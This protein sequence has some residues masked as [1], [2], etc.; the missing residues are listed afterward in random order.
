M[1]VPTHERRDR[2][3]PVITVGLDGLNI[4]TRKKFKCSICGGTVFAYYDTVVF[5][6]PVDVTQSPDN[7]EF[8]P[9][10]GAFD[11]V[12]CTHYMKDDSGKRQRCRTIYIISRP[13]NG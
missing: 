5:L 10:D 2:T 8:A 11:E 7:E 4:H 9:A 3:V 13:D 1:L 12:E 6:M